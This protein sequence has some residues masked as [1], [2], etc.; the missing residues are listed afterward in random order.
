MN[1]P[2]ENY[3]LCVSLDTNQTKLITNGRIYEFMSGDPYY[4]YVRCNNGKK[5]GFYHEKFIKLSELFNEEELK[6]VEMIRGR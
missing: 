5:A 2:L 4:T 3:A 1:L 6:C